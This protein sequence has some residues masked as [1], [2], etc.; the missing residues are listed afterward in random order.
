M[1]GNC[2]MPRIEYAPS[3]AIFASAMYHPAS[4]DCIRISFR[5]FRTAEESRP[6]A[7]CRLRSFRSRCVF[8]F[9]SGTISA[10]INECNPSLTSR[11]SSELAH[12]RSSPGA[13]FARS[14]GVPGA[15]APGFDLTSTFIRDNQRTRGPKVAIRCSA[16]LRGH[17]RIIKRGG[18]YP[19][20]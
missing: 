19:R 4:T 8:A 5:P 15:P 17:Q 11:I 13:R 10:S 3:V 9:Y 18:K 6:P 7:P 14:S 2:G 20:S 1:S 12:P 16:L